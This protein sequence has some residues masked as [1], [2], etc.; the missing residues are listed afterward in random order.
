MTGRFSSGYIKRTLDHVEEALEGPPS[1]RADDFCGHAHEEGGS[2]A[3]PAAD[4]GAGSRC[5][6]ELHTRP[7]IEKMHSNL[8]IW[9]FFCGWVALS[10]AV[11]VPK[12]ERG[13]ALPPLALSVSFGGFWEPGTMLFPFRSAVIEPLAASFP[14]AGILIDGTWAFQEKTGSE[15]ERK[16]CLPAHAG[17]R[18][19]LLFSQ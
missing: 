13:K 1:Y 17:C 7:E 18:D 9:A 4:E 10:A 12:N 5:S 16:S 3:A 8:A 14:K 2:R 11:G 15:K 6:A 19:H